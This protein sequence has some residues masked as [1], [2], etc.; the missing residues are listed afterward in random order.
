MTHD[1][2]AAR[3]SGPDD[4]TASLI[5]AYMANNPSIGWNDT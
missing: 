1:Y 4:F 3:G 2:A 5:R